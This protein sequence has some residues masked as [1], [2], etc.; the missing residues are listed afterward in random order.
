M[1][2]NHEK[3]THIDWELGNI[4]EVLYGSSDF[5]E[6]SIPLDLHATSVF[7]TAI[8]SLGCAGLQKVARLTTEHR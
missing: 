3:Y 5:P 4:F 2:L 1:L 6:L 8:I 7:S